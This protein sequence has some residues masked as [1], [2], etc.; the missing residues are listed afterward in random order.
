M[1]FT[2]DQVRGLGCIS[3]S[4]DIERANAPLAALL[5]WA[6]RFDPVNRTSYLELRHYMGNTLLRD[7]DFMSMAHGLELRVPFIDHSLA[8]FMFRIAGVCKIDKQ[9]PKWLLVQAVQD[10]LPGE[11]VH[12]PKRGFTFPFEIW[13][14]GQLRREVE[15]VLLDSSADLVAGVD[16]KFAERVWND[17]LLGKTTWS[18][19]WA[20]YVLK[21]WTNTFLEARLSSP[22][23]DIRN[24]RQLHTVPDA[25]LPSRA[26]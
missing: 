16:R 9:H 20:L 14:K 22:G 25:V 3:D 26:S 18:R 8:E 2:P 4:A 7:A 1:L 10:T 5:K 24:L 19:P 21:R 17:F 6:Q 23:L 15:N 11:V 12:R 13:L